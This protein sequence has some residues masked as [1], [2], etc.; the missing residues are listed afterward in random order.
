MFGFYQTVL[1]A[2]N[3]DVKFTSLSLSLSLF[4]A[5]H[6]SNIYSVFSILVGPVA[7]SV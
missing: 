2:L 5:E 1:P 7:Q 6:V 3:T 4:S